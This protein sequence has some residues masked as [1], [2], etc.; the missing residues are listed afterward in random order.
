MGEMEAAFFDLDKTVISK[1]SSLALTRPMYR[2]G[3]VTRSALL[4]G[5]YAQLVY[6]LLG[7]DERK[8]E[9]AKESM[10]ALTKGWVQGQVEQ[11]VRE[12]LTDLLDPYIYLEALD[13]MELHRARG[14][15]VFIVSS[16]PEE[17]VRPLAERL[18]GVQV[19]ATRARVEDNRYT[20]ELEFYCYGE[21]KAQA[22]REHAERDGLDLA[23]SYAYSDSITD[24][25]MLEVVGN[26]I[27]VN[28][29][30]ELRREAERRGWRIRDFR[31]PVRLRERL[32][33]VGAPPPGLATLVV[34]LVGLLLGWLYLRR[35]LAARRSD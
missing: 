12:A 33:Q 25:P 11:V 21:N 15:K 23:A 19:I 30:R 3:L 13:L 22:M 9:R 32:P 18:G 5:A 6:L 26:P 8:M 20:G 7:A 14:R 28:P 17:V 34:G 2:A 35:L 27:A 4:K 24:I 29:D 16:S 10:L 31:R 1:S